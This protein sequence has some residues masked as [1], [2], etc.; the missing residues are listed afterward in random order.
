MCKSCILSVKMEIVAKP[1]LYVPSWRETEYVDVCPF[2][3]GQR[4][5]V[6][7][8]ICKCRHREDDVFHT[9]TEFNLH[10]KNKYHKMWLKNYE[11]T[12]REDIGLL[13]TENRELKRDNAILY[14]RVEKLEARIH[15]LESEDT[16]YDIN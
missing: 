4:R 11:K 10:V 16:F 15:K 6:T 7:P 8:F 2:E 13:N 3:R 9:L 14:A 5:A 1:G 12:I